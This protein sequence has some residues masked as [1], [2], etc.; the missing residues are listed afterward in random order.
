MY[1]YFTHSGQVDWS[2]VLAKIV[3]GIN[4]S[5]HRII[6]A[7]PQQVFDGVKE[8]TKAEEHVDKVKFQKGD[9]VRLSLEKHIFRKGYKSQWT[10]QVFVILRVLTTNPTTYHIIDEQGKRI[11]GIFYSPEM[12]RVQ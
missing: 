7:T 12:V 2:A 5:Y 11:Q 1:K 10:D 4:N 9:R 3:K 8:P 6:K